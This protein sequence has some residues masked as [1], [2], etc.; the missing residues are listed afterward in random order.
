MWWYTGALPSHTAPLLDE[1]GK[2]VKLNQDAFAAVNA[3][4]PN[5]E[6]EVDNNKGSP[7]AKM[8]TSSVAAQRQGVGAPSRNSGRGGLD[9][10]R[11][12][13]QVGSKK[14][15]QQAEE[16]MEED[17]GIATD[18]HRAPATKLDRI[19]MRNA[20]DHDDDDDDAEEDVGRTAI[21]GGSKRAATANRCFEE[22]QLPDSA[23]QKKKKKKLGKRERQE[24]KATI[25]NDGTGVPA[26]AK[27]VLAGVSRT[28]GIDD[29]DG[30]K[31][32][33]RKRRKVRSRQKNIR[34]DNR[35]TKPTH[36]VPGNADYRGRPLTAETRRKL[37]MSESRRTAKLKSYWQS[38]QAK[39]DG[40]GD[41]A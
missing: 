7:T 13:L 29:G 26:E 38:H 31:D 16:E 32:K 9:M 27:D 14:Q 1:K 21:D 37:N 10:H 41:D 28:G 33:K 36:L 23:G 22:E 8:S 2:M 11:R 17:F 18:S 3:A 12:V 20:H 5:V 35:E 15:K 30:N 19:D 24:Q 6:E 4:Y 25:G 39:S 40:G 34:K